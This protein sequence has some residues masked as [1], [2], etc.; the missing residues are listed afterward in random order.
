MIALLTYGSFNL[1]YLKMLDIMVWCYVSLL[2]PEPTER[3]SLHGCKNG[4]WDEQIF[5]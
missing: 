3:T 1:S 4:I 2:L 5:I